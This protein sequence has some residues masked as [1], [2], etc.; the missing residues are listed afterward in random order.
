M[1]E[2]DLPT[3]GRFSSKGSFYPDHSLASVELL[4]LYSP[5]SVGLHYVENMWKFCLLLLLKAARVSLL[6]CVKITGP[7]CLTLLR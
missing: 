7:V 6:N 5:H 1:A 4:A 3:K 2:K